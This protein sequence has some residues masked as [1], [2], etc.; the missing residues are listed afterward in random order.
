MQQK[1]IKYTANGNHFVLFD[2]GVVLNGEQIARICHPAFGVG[3]DGVAMISNEAG[4]DFRFRL[5]NSDGGE[6]EMCGNAA[7]AAA[8]HFMQTRKL[9]K[10]KFKTM[11]STYHANLEDG[12]LWIEMSEHRQDLNLPPDLFNSY[13]R[14]FYVDTGVPHL[15]LEVPDVAKIDMLAEAPRLRHHRS[16][17]RGTNVDFISVTDPAQSNVQLRVFERGVE[18]ETWSC[19][20]GVAAVAWACRA[21]YGWSGDMAVTTKGGEHRVRLDAQ[22]HLW[23]SGDIVKVF[24]GTLSV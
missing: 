22:G 11:N 7:R 6:A 2:G 16:F 23:Y 20:T 4:F 5:W 15:V 19:G 14:W 3:A 24:E 9:E 1:F 12:R 18:A 10:V 13:S 21:F 17:P 8:W